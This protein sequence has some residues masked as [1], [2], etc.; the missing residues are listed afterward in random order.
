MGSVSETR[1]KGKGR[2]G[3][4]RVGGGRRTRKAIKRSDS[5]QFLYNPDDPKKIV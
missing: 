2:V 5:R 1:K 4:G 3:K